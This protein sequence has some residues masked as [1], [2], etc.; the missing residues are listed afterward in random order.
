MNRIYEQ[1]LSGVSG[2][3][4]PGDDRQCGIKKKMT[5][6]ITI[7]YD[8]GHEQHLYNDDYG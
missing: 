1:P 5:I 6:G 2:G 4:G 7:L 8:T 3:W